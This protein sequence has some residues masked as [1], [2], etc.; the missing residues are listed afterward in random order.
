[1]DF[2]LNAVYILL[3]F[4]NHFIYFSVFYHSHDSVAEVKKDLPGYQGIVDEHERIE[5]EVKEQN[6]QDLPWE[7]KRPWIDDLFLTALSSP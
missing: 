7:N 5:R 4:S 1:M 3:F 6:S 2:T